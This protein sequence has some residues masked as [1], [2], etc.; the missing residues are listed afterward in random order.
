MGSEQ[1]VRFFWV[2]FAQFVKAFKTERFG[3]SEEFIDAGFDVFE[4]GEEVP[5]GHG[6]LIL[7]ATIVEEVGKSARS[8]CG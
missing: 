8:R 1:A 5:V 2:L 3:G 4:C 6:M 7:C